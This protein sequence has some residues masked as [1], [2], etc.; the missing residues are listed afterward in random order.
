VEYSKGN[1][2]ASTH[3]NVIDQIEESVESFSGTFR[4]SLTT[5]LAEL[6]GE[7]GKT[8][9]D[10]SGEGPELSPGTKRP[11]GKMPGPLNRRTG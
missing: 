5:P 11:G 2:G 6:R 10:F 7:E 9:V 3:C 4:Q 8:V 1:Q